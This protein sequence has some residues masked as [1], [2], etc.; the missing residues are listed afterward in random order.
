MLSTEPTFPW[1][2]TSSGEM[3]AYRSRSHFIKPMKSFVI[4]SDGVIHKDVIFAELSSFRS[5]IC[6][7]IFSPNK[8]MLVGTI[9]ELAQVFHVYNLIQEQHLPAD[10]K[11]ALGLILC[12]IG[13]QSTDSL[14]TSDTEWFSLHRLLHRLVHLLPY[15][16]LIDKLT[17]PDEE[18]SL[19]RAITIFSDPDETDGSI[20]E[21]DDKV[22]SLWLVEL[23]RGFFPALRN[24]K[25]ESQR[26]MNLV[27]ATVKEKSDY[28]IIDLMDMIN[29]QEKGMFE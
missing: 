22:L 29:R 15:Q 9:L 20:I 21:W 6:E 17:D 16:T 5:I 24:I 25:Q 18:I 7:G 19:D 11:I 14:L 10:G 3:I 2:N 1:I 8:S 23:A 4:H 27:C 12:S 26:A 28:R 13:A